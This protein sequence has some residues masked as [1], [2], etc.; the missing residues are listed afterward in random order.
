MREASGH[1]CHMLVRH[2]ERKL[3]DQF[4]VA[5]ADHLVN[6]PLNDSLETSS[7]LVVIVRWRLTQDYGDAE[8]FSVLNN[9]SSA[10]LS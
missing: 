4:A 10:I 5:A 6:I 8:L 7:H 9:S 1:T 2:R 3:I